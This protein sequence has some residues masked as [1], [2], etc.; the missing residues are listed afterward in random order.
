MVLWFYIFIHIRKYCFI[1]ITV[2]CTGINRRYVD[3]L[4]L[5]YGFKSRH[6]VIIAETLTSGKLSII[7]S[8]IAKTEIAI[9]R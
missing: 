5:I 3:I 2:F 4:E 8:E 6:M 1:D 7:S 9:S